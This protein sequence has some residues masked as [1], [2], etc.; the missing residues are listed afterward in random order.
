MHACVWVCIIGHVLIYGIGKDILIEC[1]GRE[2]A[3]GGG[4]GGGRNGMSE[5]GIRGV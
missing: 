2:G 4:G 5:R 3:M 1:V